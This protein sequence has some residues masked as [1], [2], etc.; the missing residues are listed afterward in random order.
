[1][2]RRLAISRASDAEQ[3][4]AVALNCPWYVPTSGVGRLS[5]LG[6]DQTSEGMVQ[7]R[8]WSIGMVVGHDGER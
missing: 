7:H 3:Q 1:M 6:V 4:V 5:M 2:G 8:P